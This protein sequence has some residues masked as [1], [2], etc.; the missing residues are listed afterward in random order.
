[1]SIITFDTLHYANKLLEKGFS[2]EQSEAI[3]TLQKDVLNEALEGQL[4]TKKDTW[5]IQ[6]ELKTHRWM[7]GFL[8]SGVAALVLKTFFSV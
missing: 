1:M 2:K 7:L 6:S 4:A 5:I 8:L 3:V